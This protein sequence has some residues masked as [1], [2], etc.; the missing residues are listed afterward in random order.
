MT[1]RVFLVAILVSLSMLLLAPA[2]AK[3][4]D[5]D[6]ALQS[7]FLSAVT[8][9]DYPQEVMNWT[10]TPCKLLQQLNVNMNMIDVVH[11]TTLDLVGYVGWYT[12]VN[13]QSNIVVAAFRGTEPDSW[14]N[15]LLDFDVF[16]TQFL[17]DNPEYQNVKVHAGFLNGHYALRP[18]MRAALAKAFLDAKPSAIMFSGHSLGAAIATLAALDLEFSPDPAIDIDNVDVSLYTFG[19]PRVGNPAFAQLFQQDSILGRSGRAYRVVH[20]EDI[21]PHIPIELM[22]YRHITTEVF[23]LNASSDTDTFQ[24]CTNPPIGE[25]PKCSNRFIFP[26]SIFDH[27]NYFGFHVGAI[28]E[29]PIQD[30]LTV[31]VKKLNLVSFED[32][33]KTRGADFWNEFYAAHGIEPPTTNLTSV[34]F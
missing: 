16:F 31:A 28:C 8:Y 7:L 4:Y 32:E 13:T 27:V 11:D 15:W 3:T 22:G 10:C 23:Y 14:R 12:D 9:C 2:T 18:R 5:P 34:G 24:V 30:E 19:S 6:L 33:L 26:T 25:D 17:P 1:P 20:G 29:S 21:V